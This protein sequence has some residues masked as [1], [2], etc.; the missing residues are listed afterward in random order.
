M[1]TIG[2]GGDCGDLVLEHVGRG[3]TEG[4]IVAWLPKHQD[5][6]RR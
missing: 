1:V 3:H 5:P 6:L 4:D 2:P